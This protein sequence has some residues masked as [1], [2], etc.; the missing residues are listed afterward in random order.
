[1]IVYVL[2]NERFVQFCR[3]HISESFHYFIVH[4]VRPFTLW[5]AFV[6]IFELMLFQRR[7]AHCSFLASDI[8]L[9]FSLFSRVRIIF[10]RRGFRICQRI[11]LG[12]IGRTITMNSGVT[13]TTKMVRWLGN[14]YE[15]FAKTPLYPQGQPKLCSPTKLLS[16]IE[17]FCNESNRSTVHKQ[18]SMA[19]PILASVTRVTPLVML[20]ANRLIYLWLMGSFIHQDTFLS[21]LANGIVNSESVL[22]VTNENAPSPIELSISTVHPSKCTMNRSFQKKILLTINVCSI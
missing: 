7:D 18:S 8:S 2:S 20:I 9:Q 22:S 14:L 21:P 16:I 15:S 11:C 17:I 13:C 4:S 5:F 19:G 1:M 10:V 12:V 6:C 3:F